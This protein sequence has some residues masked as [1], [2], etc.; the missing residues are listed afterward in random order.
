[1][2]SLYA[3][4]KKL[5]KNTDSS[6]QRNTKIIGDLITQNPQLTFAFW[7]D[8]VEDG[9]TISLSINN[10]WITEDFPVK[11]KPQFITVSLQPGPNLITFIPKN[12]GS[13]PPNTS[14]LEIIDG[15]KR[16]SF[17]IETDMN[18]NNQVN[19]Y[20]DIR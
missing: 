3:R 5:K 9:D 14:V 4:F 2:N 1:M 13:I 12:L 17:Y 6:I 20:Y 18:L 15:K 11:K 19:I 10:Q 16:K 7:D 8:A